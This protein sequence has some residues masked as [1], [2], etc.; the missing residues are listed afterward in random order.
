MTSTAKKILD[1]ALA[2]PEDDRAVLVDALT[3]SLVQ[4]EGELSAEWKAEIRRRI[5]AAERDPSR[6]L[7]WDDVVGRVEATLADV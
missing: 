3:E 2:L 6:L 4:A 7:E 1:E 5:E